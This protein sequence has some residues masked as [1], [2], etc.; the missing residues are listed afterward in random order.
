MKLSQHSEN[1]TRSFW[2]MKTILMK[3]VHFYT[4]ILY[5]GLR[6]KENKST[7]DIIKEKF[8]KSNAL[9]INN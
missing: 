5:R 3:G 1:Y 6:A 4:W 7:G 8:T 9:N 2:L